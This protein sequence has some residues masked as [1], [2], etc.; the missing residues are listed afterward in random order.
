M[1]SDL[2]LRSAE[3]HQ[4]GISHQP[5]LRISKI[6]HLHLDNCG[7]T[8]IGPEISQC[9][10]LRVLYLYSNAIRKISHLVSAQGLTHLYLQNNAINK[11]EGMDTLVNLRKLYLDRN[12][13]SKLENLDSCL[14]LEELHM[15]QQN[16]D[17]EETFVLNVDC[18]LHLGN[19]RTLRIVHL[20][21]NQITDPSPLASVGSL[22]QI[23]LESNRIVELQGILEI[24][25]KCKQLTLMNLLRCPVTL[26][27]KYRDMVIVAGSS[28]EE[29]DHEN[30]NPNHRK[31]LV[32]LQTSKLRKRA[33]KF[34]C[35]ENSDVGNTS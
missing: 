20:A 32:S 1:D 24:L 16:L 15:S 19:H 12:R 4:T 10:S 11:I 6:T 25:T 26:S 8:D 23:D 28:L 31:F 3:K 17:C 22:T 27:A 18:M 2:I 5:E 13:I 34:A 9:R 29:L 33:D 35:A 30:V 21:H 14:Q 7:I